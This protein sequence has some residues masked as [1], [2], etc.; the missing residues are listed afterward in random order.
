M[1]QMNLFVGKEWRHGL[2]E[3]TYGPRRGRR[4]WDKLTEQH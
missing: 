4:G 3:R 2:R 1:I